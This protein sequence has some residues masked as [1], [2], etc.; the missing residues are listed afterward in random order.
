M[1]NAFARPLDNLEQLWPKGI[2]QMTLDEQAAYA[3]YVCIESASGHD[4]CDE[5]IK[6]IREDFPFHPPCNTTGLANLAYM[7]KYAH[8]T[9]RDEFSNV[10]L[11]YSALLKR[12]YRV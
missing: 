4:F 2:L 10:H 1:G 3:D 7:S 8:P 11:A 12:K 5:Q 6:S 9:F